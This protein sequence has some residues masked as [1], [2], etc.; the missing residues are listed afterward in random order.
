MLCLYAKGFPV[1]ILVCSKSI[2]GDNATMGQVVLLLATA[3]ISGLL[4]TCV[5]LFWQR[6]TEAFNRKMNVFRTL[7][8][9]RYM[10]SSEECV[11]ALNT[12]DIVFYKDKNVREAYKAFWEEASKIP[13]S[14]QA[15]DEKFL[16]LLDVMA[17]SLK[18]EDIHWD[19]IKHYYYPT[20]LAESLTE[21]ATLRKLQ[22]QSV[23]NSLSTST[24]RK[25]ISQNNQLMEKVFLSVLP[26][27]IKDPSKIE[28][29]ATM[30]EKLNKK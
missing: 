26:E 20:G 22:I 17:R 8:S 10:V 27:L 2:K 9:N 6:K 7:M 18:L 30:S 11:N 24:E 16:K 29:L 14:F 15:T 21:E 13:F 23:S 4:A 1:K 28:Q 3:L 12:I 5:T 25:N 19:E